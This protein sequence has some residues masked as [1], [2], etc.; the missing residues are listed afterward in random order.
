MQFVA[1]LQVV[2]EKLRINLWGKIRGRLT[3]KELKHIFFLLIKCCYKYLK[4]CL[5]VCL[6]SSHYKYSEFLIHFFFFDK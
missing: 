3:A 4:N 5:K 1:L 6:I 2:R